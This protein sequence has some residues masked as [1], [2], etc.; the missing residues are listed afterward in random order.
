MATGERDDTESLTISTQLH[1]T[2]LQEQ[3]LEYEAAHDTRSEA[4]RNAVREQIDKKDS[5]DH[6]TQG[7]AAGVFTLLVLFIYQI[8][9]LTNWVTA[10]LSLAAVL[11][12]FAVGMALPLERFQP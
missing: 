1:S 7:V 12:V 5:I 9:V 11:V 6:L 8:A 10:G 2:E 4:L 3:F